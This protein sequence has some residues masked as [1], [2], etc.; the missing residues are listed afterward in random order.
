M[1]W[2]NVGNQQSAKIGPLLFCTHIYRVPTI[3]HLL[4]NEPIIANNGPILRERSLLQL[5]DVSIVT[6][7]NY[8]CKFINVHDGKVDDEELMRQNCLETYANLID[9]LKRNESHTGSRRLS[10]ILCGV[11]I[12]GRKFE[13]QRPDTWFCNTSKLESTLFQFNSVY[14][15]ADYPLMTLSIQHL[16]PFIYPGIMKQKG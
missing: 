16:N 1:Y 5:E 15:S 14:C 2:P 13:L 12:Q 3:V 8:I 4:D 11:I 6:F 7:A 9:G 10:G